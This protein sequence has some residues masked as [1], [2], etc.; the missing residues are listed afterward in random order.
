[1]IS[2]KVQGWIG[3]RLGE[4][5]RTGQ[6]EA[7]GEE[8]P[9]E[10]YK[11]RVQRAKERLSEQGLDALIVWADSYRMSNV[12]WLVNYRTIDGIFPQ[13]MLVYLTA[14]SDP[15][16]FLP[17]SHIG[18]AHD[19]SMIDAL[20]G[21]V[22]EIRSELAPFLKE[23]ARQDDPRRVGISGYNFMDLEFWPPIAEAF[24]DADVQKVDII[25]RLKSKKIEAELNSMRR[26]GRASAAGIQMLMDLLRD[27]ERITEQEATSLVYA[28][29]FANG[30]HSIAYDIMIQAGEHTRNLFTLPTDRPIQRGDIVM[31]DYGC[32]VNWYSS[33]NARTIAYGPVTDEQKHLMEACTRGHEHG[34]KNIKA[35]MTAK[36]AD[37]VIR[38][39][40]R[41]EGVEEYLEAPSEGRNGVHATG[42]DPE[43]E[44]PGMGPGIDEVYEAGQT[45]A[46]ELSLIK[47]G[48]AGVR[49]EDA[50]VVR[51]DGLE[52][53]HDFPHY[54]YIE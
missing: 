26:A 1:M 33:D 17:P 11:E 48:V 52:P 53:L 9:V 38:Q 35:G 21:D 39:V 12:R 50:V 28:A 42:M 37:E 34:L 51:E 2:E 36:E 40:Y 13:P 15:V 14:D 22:R 29:M 45:F 41:E 23:R 4:L 31:M 7:Y 43:E 25:E 47:P 8:I 16:L 3:E 19:H 30:A 5:V 10:V 49:T 46:Y 20:G 24:S 44:I 32:R 54:L 18:S 6:W 27:G